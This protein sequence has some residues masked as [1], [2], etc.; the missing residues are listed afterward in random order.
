MDVEVIKVS[1][2]EVILTNM[3]IA[4]IEN[5]PAF[6][7]YRKL[8][9]SDTVWSREIETD[10]TICGEQ[11]DVPGV[12]VLF[13]LHI[14]KDGINVEFSG[15]CGEQYAL[16]IMKESDPQKGIE[17]PPGEEAAADLKDT[18]ALLVPDYLP[19]EL[20]DGADALFYFQFEI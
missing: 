16:Y 19:E 9:L 10:L 3:D 6:G 8:A 17:V 1:M 18:V 4:N 14:T 12:G 2:R 11:I 15:D 13:E 5:D 7:A 20:Y